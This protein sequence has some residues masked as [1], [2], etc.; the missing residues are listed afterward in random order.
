[1]A[2]G[3]KDVTCSTE[4]DLTEKGITPMGGF[5]HY[6]VVREDWLMLKGCVPG[7]KKR[8]VTLRKTIL[9]SNKRKEPALLK[10]IDTSSKFG[11]GRYQT[12]EEKEK[13]LGR[14]KEGEGMDKEL[15]KRNQKKA[16]VG[17]AL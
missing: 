17:G 7:V 12:T 1:M 11:H 3:A 14:T 5:P 10:F 8:V 4:T 13:F 2:E 16:K 15:N 9:V 6:G